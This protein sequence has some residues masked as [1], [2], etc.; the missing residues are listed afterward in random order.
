MQ[1][2]RVYSF[3]AA[4]KDKDNKDTTTRES[5]GKKKIRQAGVF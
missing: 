1:F 4:D 5:N 3:A 2:I